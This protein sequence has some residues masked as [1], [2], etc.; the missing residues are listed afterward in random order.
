M[1]GL[2][3]PGPRPGRFGGHRS[4]LEEGTLPGGNP[5]RVFLRRETGVDPPSPGRA[6]PAPS[7][8]E[9][10]GRIL[11]PRP[12]VPEP[13]PIHFLERSRSMGCHAEPA[14]LAGAPAGPVPGTLRSPGPGGPSRAG[15]QVGRSG[16]EAV[17][18]RPWRSEG[19]PTI[20]GGGDADMKAP[21]V[22][23]TAAGAGFPP[24]L[25]PPVRPPIAL[26]SIDPAERNPGSSR[27]LHRRRARPANT[28][29][30]AHPPVSL[31][32]R[33]EWRD[34]HAGAGRSS[35]DQDVDFGLP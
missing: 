3:A 16:E 26:E 5:R 29:P 6:G 8:Q 2:G 17:P 30:G 1:G 4:R 9:G 22:P 7:G 27:G 34:C 25:R 19:I 18:R 24:R 10:R 14:A 28:R 23:G 20:R 12:A 32:D 11:G 33:R 21:E 15:L 13:P 31:A 35:Q